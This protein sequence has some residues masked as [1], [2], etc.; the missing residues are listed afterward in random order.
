M[1]I[2]NSKLFFTLCLIG[3]TLS[4]DIINLKVLV[5]SPEVDDDYNRLNE[6]LMQNFDIKIN[7]AEINNKASYNAI[8]E[9]DDFFLD[10]SETDENNDKILVNTFKYKL[11]IPGM[12]FTDGDANVVYNTPEIFWRP[13]NSAFS[14]ATNPKII[15]NQ[16]NQNDLKFFI[17][18]NQMYFDM[19]MT[20]SIQKIEI[21]NTFENWAQEDLKKN[22]KIIL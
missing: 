18:I 22:K 21:D 10:D 8:I 19:S 16:F 12:K 7:D 13:P 17:E 2:E 6:Q 5:A 15:A 14:D 3:M 9:V 20:I 1:K 11:T 4:V